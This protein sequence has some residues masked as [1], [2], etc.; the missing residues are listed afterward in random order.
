MGKRFRNVMTGCRD[1]RSETV[2]ER[3]KVNLGHADQKIQYTD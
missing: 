3:S 2:C 1:A